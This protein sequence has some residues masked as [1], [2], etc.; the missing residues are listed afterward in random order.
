MISSNW[1]LVVAGGSGT[2]MGT[3][4]PKQFLPLLNKPVLLHA[5]ER[6]LLFDPHINL[7]VV[8]PEN[9]HS[10]W[11]AICEA[12]NFHHTHLVVSGG[13]TRFQSVKNGLAAIPAEEGLVAVHDGVRPLVSTDTLSRC[14]DAAKRF[15]AAVPVVPLIDSLRQVN[16]NGSRSVDRNAYCLVQTPQTFNLQT[17]KTAYET[18][19]SPDFTDDASVWE[20]QGLSLATVAGNPENIKITRL[21]DLRIA[22]ALMA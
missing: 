8:L 12:Q 5:L 6:L 22:E 7:V 9:H 3:E 18:E 14:F 15:G 2:R 1:A 19:E 4:T 21:F 13:S 17:L 16:A 10:T 11:K 20:R